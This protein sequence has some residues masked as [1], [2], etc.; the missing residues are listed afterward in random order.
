[1]SVAIDHVRQDFK[2]SDDMRDAGLVIPEDIVCYEN[3]VY[4]T[5]PEWQV[6]DIYQTT[7]SEGKLLPVIVCVHD[8]GLVSGNKEHYK[9]YCMDLAQRG[10]AVVNFT[11]RLT[12]EH[13]YP[14]PLE[15]TNSVFSWILA[16]AEQYY[17]DKK[18]VFAVGDS[19]GAHI[20]GLYAGICTNPDYA[21][22]YSFHPPTGFALKAIAL[23]CGTKEDLNSKLITDLLPDQGSTAEMELID[24]TAHITQDYP[25]TFLMTSTDDLLKD[26]TI[27]MATKLT[28][29]NVPFTY[30]YYGNA[31]NMLPHA[32]YLNTK[33]VEAKLCNDEECEFFHKY[34]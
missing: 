7:W 14:A 29:K 5:D 16:N 4:G 26:Q 11:Y 34:L 32:F 22:K 19:T 3:I 8:G 23:N 15:D 10:F 28:A 1:M 9:Y 6:L 20:L 31:L 13:K 25:P 12:P 27:A 17:L 24:V 18:N 21:A 2:R 33:S 30:R